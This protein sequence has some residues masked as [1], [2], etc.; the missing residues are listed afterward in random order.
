MRTSLVSGAMAF[1]PASVSGRSCDSSESGSGRRCQHVNSASVNRCLPI[2]VQLLPAA[3]TDATL[4]V[5]ITD[6]INGSTPITD[7]GLTA[8]PVRRSPDR[9]TDPGRRRSPWPAG[10]RLLRPTPRGVPSAS[11]SRPGRPA[12]RSPAAPRRTRR[13]ACVDT[14]LTTSAK[15]DVPTLVASGTEDRSCQ[16]PQPPTGC[17]AG[18]PTRAPVVWSTGLGLGRRSLAIRAAAS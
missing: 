16:S 14:W 6:P 5:R 15:I 4:V 10:K 11:V 9:R 12:S 17:P 3:A 18:S 13:N 7:C 8:R 2:E 1:R